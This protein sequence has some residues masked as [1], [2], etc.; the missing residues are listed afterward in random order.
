[1]NEKFHDPIVAE[2]RK[3]REEWFAEFDYDPV[4]LRE[5]LDAQRPKWEAAGLRFETEERRQARLARSRQRREAEARSIA[6]I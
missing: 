4:K 6:S 5:H 1:M 2:V 3:N